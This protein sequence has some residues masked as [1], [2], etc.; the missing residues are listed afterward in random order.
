MEYD[1]IFI[2]C[3]NF[4]SSITCGDEVSDLLNNA[5]FKSKSIF[6]REYNKRIVSRVVILLKPSLKIIKNIFSTLNSSVVKCVDVID[7]DVNMVNGI[8]HELVDIYICR[9]SESMKIHSKNNPHHTF[10]AIPHYISPSF[11]IESENESSF[12]VGFFGTLT[13]G[14]ENTTKEPIIT[15]LRKYNY[16]LDN[17]CVSY[18]K[19]PLES[20][21]RECNMHINLRHASF[22]PSNKI[23]QA[24]YCK[25]NILCSTNAGGVIESLGSDYPYL[26]DH[27]VNSARDILNKAKS[28]FG[29]NRWNYGLEIMQSV[30]KRYGDETI[31]NRYKELM[32]H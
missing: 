8:A 4:S 5:G 17:K 25:S 11:R 18:K 12:K 6:A 10:K 13:T 32:N 29:G 26:C 14:F 23:I 30:L 3:S 27:N 16:N 9:T 7:F 15:F 28:D 1:F 31:V 20:G 21:F 24:A 2:K 19:C 22:K